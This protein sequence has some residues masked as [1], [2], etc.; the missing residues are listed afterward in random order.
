MRRVVVETVETA[1]SSPVEGDGKI[2]PSRGRRRLRRAGTVVMVVGVVLIGYAAAVLLWRDPAT[3]LYARWQ[4]HQLAQQFEAVVREYEASA[5]SLPAEPASAGG[6]PSG[7]AA[8]N[9]VHEAA[10][11]FRRQ[12]A[13]G[14][15]IGRIVIPKLGVEKVVV[16]GTRWGADLSRGPGRYA[17]TSVP[18]L[19]KTVGIAGHRTTFGAPFRHI[20]RLERGDSVEL[21]LPYG[22]FHYR[23]FLHEIVDSDDWSVIRNRGFDTLML[24]ACHPLYAA[25]HRWIVYAR[26]VSVDLPGGQSVTVPGG[27]DLSA[28][29][30]T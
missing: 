28:A 6:D 13:E 4:Q 20:D 29:A 2:S 18:G 24:S 19:G 23:V 5:P 8:P 26:L 27:A 16:N 1:P 7:A 17:Q 21:V 12:L 30:K 25:S 9:A 22:T 10:V 11:R 15:P 3:D 14:E